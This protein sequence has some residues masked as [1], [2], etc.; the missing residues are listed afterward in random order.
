VLQLGADAPTQQRLREAVRR[1]A[2][3]SD[4]DEPE[5]SWSEGAV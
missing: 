1:H 4:D 2:V 3:P 5:E